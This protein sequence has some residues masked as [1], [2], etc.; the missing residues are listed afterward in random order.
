MVL[1]RLI[2]SVKVATACV[3]TIFRLSDALDYSR[4]FGLIFRTALNFSNPEQAGVYSCLT[5]STEI[6]TAGTVV[7]FSSQ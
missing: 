2:C 3:I 5:I 4:T 1:N 6:S 7:L